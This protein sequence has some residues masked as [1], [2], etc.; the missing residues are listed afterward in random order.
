MRRPIEPVITGEAVQRAS[1]PGLGAK[2]SLH[3]EAP[4]QGPC[5]T[6]APYLYVEVDERRGGQLIASLSRPMTSAPSGTQSARMLLEKKQPR[7]RSPSYA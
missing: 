1:S 4:D 3:L 2:A 6:L 5:K 7:L